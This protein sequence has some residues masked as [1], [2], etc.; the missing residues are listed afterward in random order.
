MSVWNSRF[1]LVYNAT[2]A[3]EVEFESTALYHLAAGVGGDG[4]EFVFQRVCRVP[5]M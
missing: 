5:A 1:V 3:K 4:G 2:Y